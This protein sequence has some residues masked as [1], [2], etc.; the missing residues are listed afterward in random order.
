MTKS[1]EK[2]KKNKGNNFGA[3]NDFSFALFLVS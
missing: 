3:L 1:Q 2:S